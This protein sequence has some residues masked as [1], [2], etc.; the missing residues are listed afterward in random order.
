[1]FT[2]SN[3]S[4]QQ[5]A[6]PHRSPPLQCKVHEIKYIL[7]GNSI[8]FLKSWYYKKYKKLKKPTNFV[9]PLLCHLCKA[10]VSE[11]EGWNSHVVS[12]HPS[13]SLRL[14][15]AALRGHSRPWRH[16][17]DRSELWKAAG[18]LASMFLPRSVADC[19]YKNI[20][21]NNHVLN[22]D[23]LNLGIPRTHHQL[24]KTAHGYV[25]NISG[26]V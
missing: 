23:S 15:E 19:E 21:W 11:L 24:M 22:F 20:I 8:F 25:L 26:L 3:C 12:N 4:S 5:R 10:A 18:G 17:R 13:G 2:R 9:C 7:D 6:A 1:M 16:V 14:F